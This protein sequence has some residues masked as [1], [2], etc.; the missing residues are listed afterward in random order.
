MTHALGYLR[1]QT[2]HGHAVI[3]PT[4]EDTEKSASAQ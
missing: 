3:V 1:R 4:G 2:H